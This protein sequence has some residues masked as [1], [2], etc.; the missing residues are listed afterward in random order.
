MK[1]VLV[2]GVHDKVGGVETFVRNLVANVPEVR[3]D[4]TSYYSKLCYEDEYISAGGSIFRIPDFHNSPLKYYKAIRRILNTNRYDAV[5]CN[6]LSG[7]NILPILAAHRAHIPTIIA[8][9][10]NAGTPSRFV[11]A[12]LNLI[13]RQLINKWVDLR[14]SCSAE[15]AIFLFGSDTGVE[16]IPN[17]V[18]SSRFLYD[19]ELRNRERNRLGIKKSTMVIGFV[20]RFS[21]QKNPLR[22]IDLFSEYHRNCADSK[23]VLVGSGEMQD[24]LREKVNML[25]I[26]DAVIFEGN[27][28]DV[29]AAYNSFD[30]LLLPSFFEG[31]PI[32]LI[33][34]Q[35]CGLPY[36]A[37]DTISKESCIVDTLGVYLSLDESDNR[38]SACIR[39]KSDNERALYSLKVQASQWNISNQAQRFKQLFCA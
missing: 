19:L 39:K 14:W 8:H 5:Y 4:F 1:R 31:L 21:L 22:L 29:E 35:A 20:G 7:A 11:K 28:M 36:I 25:H 18:D 34:A 24:E 32:A 27:R 26:Q 6:M 16:I 37:S 30:C 17:A 38:W 33:E 15:A 12:P 2:F 3:F 10:H 13:N 9:S 23:L